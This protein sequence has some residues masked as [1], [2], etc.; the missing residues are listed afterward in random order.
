MEHE[1]PAIPDTAEQRALIK[2]HNAAI[3]RRHPD[4][5]PMADDIP[6]KEADHG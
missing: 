1:Y 3:R 2:D 4:L 5:V 6:K